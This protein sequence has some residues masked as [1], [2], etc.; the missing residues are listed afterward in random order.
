M[1]SFR[2]DIRSFDRY[3]SIIGLFGV[4]D[5]GLGVVAGRASSRVRFANFIFLDFGCGALRFGVGLE[6]GTFGVGAQVRLANFSFLKKRVLEPVRPFGK[7]FEAVQRSFLA[8]YH[9]AI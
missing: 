3:S 1:S 9:D 5:A 7:A 4:C 2:F 6:S 8:A